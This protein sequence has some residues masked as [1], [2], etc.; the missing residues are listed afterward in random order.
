MPLPALTSRSRTAWEALADVPVTFSPAVRIAMSPHS[1]LC[2]AGWVGVVVIA[3]AAIATA[4]GPALARTVQE[5]VGGLAPASVTDAG[6]LSARLPVA[7]M[8]GPA[9]LAYLDASEFRPR[10]GQAV[11]EPLHPRA[12][13]LGEFLSAIDPADRD[14]SGIEQITSPAFAIREHGQIVAVAGYRDWPG[15]LAH[16]SVLTAAPARGRGL[17]GI[18]AT[19]AVTQALRKDRLPQWRARPEASR[20]VARALGFR[21]LGSQASI[22]LDVTG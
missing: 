3:D 15:Q 13:E 10:Q 9:C 4:P 19:A 1:R 2:P 7:E 21:E 14:E 5:A 11:P 8:L 12:R 16:L 17:A 6:E 22:R 20:R 18:A